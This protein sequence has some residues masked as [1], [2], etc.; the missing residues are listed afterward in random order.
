MTSPL[1]CGPSLKQFYLGPAGNLRLLTMPDSGV[2]VT[3][4]QGKVDHQ[5]V[6]G[7]HGVQRLG[8]TR[9][10]YELDFSQ[11]NWDE[12]DLV[13]SIY[14]GMLGP[15]PYY[16][17]DP[18]WRNLLPAHISGGGQ[19][20]ATSAGFFPSSGGSV[21]FAATSIT[22]PANAPLCGVQDWTPALNSFLWLNA[23]AANI[24]EPG[25]PPVNLSEPFTAATWLRCPAG[26]TQVQILAYFADINGASLGT[27]SLVASA[28]V[29]TTWQRFGAALA[30][31]S[32]PASA[33]TYG[34]VL[35]ALSAGPPH[36]YVS[37]PDIQQISATVDPADNGP[38]GTSLPRW[39]LGLG[40]PK[41]LPNSTMAANAERY[42]ARR[43]HVLT[44]VEAE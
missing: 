22:P 24:T 42:Y 41:M 26:T 5:L 11:R 2:K 33:V 23:S 39:V 20:D 8:K 17:I 10:I 21:A 38:A 28:T 35:K 12:A 34:I 15:G 1:L 43:S 14:A 36:V 31:G 19:I 16:L 27:V 30:P 18:A 25:A 7:S 32:V 6:G 40:V 44:L 3:L 37:A 4:D 29:T 9:R 13:V